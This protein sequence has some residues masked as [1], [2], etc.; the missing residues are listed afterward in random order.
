MRGQP[1]ATRRELLSPLRYMSDVTRRG[2]PPNLSRELH[3]I[4]SS[5]ST[6]TGTL[7]D[8]REAATRRRSIRTFAASSI[9]TKIVK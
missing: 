6:N 9:T 7:L 8:V 1:A 3:V 5:D 2:V 4:D